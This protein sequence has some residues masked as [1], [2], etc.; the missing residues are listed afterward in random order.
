[1]GLKRLRAASLSYHEGTGTVSIC[2]FRITDSTV[3]VLEL[4]AEVCPSVVV[5]LLEGLQVCLPAV[6]GVC[7]AV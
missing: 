6:A 1:M 7:R 3:L 4:H 5:F 2:H